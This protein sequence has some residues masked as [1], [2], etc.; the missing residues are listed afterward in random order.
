MQQSYNEIWNSVLEKLKTENS[1]SVYDLWFADTELLFLDNERA[2]VCIASDLKCDILSKRYLPI[3]HNALSEIIG[4]DIEVHLRSSEHEKPDLADFSIDLT[5]KQKSNIQNP[6]Y[7]P[8]V[9]KVEPRQIYSNADFTFDN[10]IVGSSNRYPHAACM[11]VAEHP[12]VEYNPLFIYGPSG[13]GKTHLLYA[14]MNKVSEDHPEMNI[15]YIRGE[16]FTNELIESIGKKSQIQ[17]RNKYRN[18]DLLLIDDIQFIAGKESIQEEFFNTFNALYEDHRQIVLVADRPPR[19]MKTLEDRLKTRFEWGLLADIQ[20]PDFELR[21]AILKNKA[22]MIGVNIPYDVLNFLAENLKS[23]IRQLEGA[24][25]RISAHSFLNGV[26]ITREMAQV[27]ISDMITAD[28]SPA[29]TVENI[30][31]K[32]CKKYGLSEDDIKG[33]KKTKEI[34]MA[35][36]ICI[37]II[38]KMTDLS[39]PA[40]GR[41]LGRDHTTVMSSLQVIEN[42]LRTNP[43]L[44]IEINDIIREVRE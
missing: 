20:P 26:P 5:P 24:V 15:I 28:E 19:D 29:M 35:R 38:R 25:K 33:R 2:V 40:I 7:I 10:F 39:L 6:N 18:A 16:E 43:L 21:S 11:A 30:I 44:D 34:A 8:A 22:K 41:I 42:E 31:S 13:L 14:I 12:A 9:P 23:N 4:F 27:C 36:H 37:Y 1:K 32:V 3:I 17:F